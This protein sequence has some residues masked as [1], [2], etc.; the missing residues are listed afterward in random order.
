MAEGGGLP[1]DPPGFDKA[2]QRMA[3]GRKRAVPKF[4]ELLRSSIAITTNSSS[5]R[6]STATRTRSAKSSTNPSEIDETEDNATD[7]ETAPSVT[8][9]KPF[10][11]HSQHR[12]QERKEHRLLLFV[13]VDLPNGK[14][15][16]IG[17][18]RGDD[19]ETLSHNFCVTY[20]LDS[21]MKANLCT[22]LTEKIEVTLR[23]EEV[24]KAFSK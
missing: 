17:V 4:E 6:P 13:D 18:H 23:A 11:L 7:T 8:E 21:E 14:T 1:A 9:T 16:R 22:M 5:S 3:E 10:N 2:I 20:S 15:G 12:V 19:P 24:R